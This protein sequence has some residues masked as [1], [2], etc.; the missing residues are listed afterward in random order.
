MCKAVGKGHEVDSRLLLRESG[1]GAGLNR[2]NG[3]SSVL[4][5]YKNAMAVEVKQAIRYTPP[6]MGSC[7]TG[8]T[9]RFGLAL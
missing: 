7:V 1:V 3:L 2:T 4:K 9:G 5:A 8:C 6:N